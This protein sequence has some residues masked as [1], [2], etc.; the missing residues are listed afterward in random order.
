MELCIFSSA[1]NCSYE[2]D[3]EQFIADAESIVQKMR[4]RRYE[5]TI[6]YQKF[7]Y[8]KPYLAHRAPIAMEEVPWKVLFRPMMTLTMSQR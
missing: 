5:V 8:E 3:Q 6:C 7:F 1:F 4:L 2:V